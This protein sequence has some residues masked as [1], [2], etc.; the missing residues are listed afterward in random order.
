LRRRRDAAA[1]GA[2]A[3]EFEDAADKAGATASSFEIKLILA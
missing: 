2:E 1:A 3:S